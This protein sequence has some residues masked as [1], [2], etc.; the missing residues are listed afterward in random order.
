MNPSWLISTEDVLTKV[1]V[2][3]RCIN[4]HGRP[5]NTVRAR[6]RKKILLTQ[7]VVGRNNMLYQ[8]QVSF[9]SLNPARPYLLPSFL[10]RFLRE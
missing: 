8:S 2:V 5:K 6:L 9:V 10:T 4:V 1:R 3:S 7:R